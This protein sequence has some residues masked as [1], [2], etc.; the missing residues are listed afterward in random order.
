MDSPWTTQSGFTAL[1]E[2]KEYKTLA[3]AATWRGYFYVFRQDFSALW[4]GCGE[5]K[6]DGADRF[7]ISLI[8]RRAG[9]GRRTK[10]LKLYQTSLCLDC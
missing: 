5:R 10:Y 9:N 2:L 7:I 4:A 8:M 6:N 1:W 3:S